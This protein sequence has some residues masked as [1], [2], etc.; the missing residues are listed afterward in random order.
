MSL[1][2]YVAL[3][4]DLL[5]EIEDV[6]GALN[7]LK[8]AVDTTLFGVDDVVEQFT[9]DYACTPDQYL[10]DIL[11]SVGWSDSEEQIE[12]ELLL[13]MDFDSI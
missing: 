8:D 9:S 10:D 7:E 4:V 3:L 13:D 1:E 2:D 5:T 12:D 6:D 11:N